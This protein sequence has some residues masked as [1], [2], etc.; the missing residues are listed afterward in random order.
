MHVGLE[1]TEKVEC[2][3]FVSYVVSQA[4]WRSAY[5]VRV[6]TKDKAMKASL[7]HFSFIPTQLYYLYVLSNLLPIKCC[8]FLFCLL[9]S[10]YKYF[11][12]ILQNWRESAIPKLNA[13]V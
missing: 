10:G 4:S 2:V 7:Y 13:K 11:L 3:L 8:L 6:F 5:D 12:S 9:K 1:T